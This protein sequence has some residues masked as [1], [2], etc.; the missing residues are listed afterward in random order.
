MKIAK[1]VKT[2]FPAKDIVEAHCDGPCGVYDP[3]SARIAAEAELA[4]AQAALRQA[5]AQ[6]LAAH[7]LHHDEADVVLLSDIM[8]G[9]D[10]GVVLPNEINQFLRGWMMLKFLK[11]HQYSH[12]LWSYFQSI[13]R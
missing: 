3:A 11:S 13:L 7:D 6:R 2:L 10:V 4:N 1:L 8:D 5:V 9:G 12:T